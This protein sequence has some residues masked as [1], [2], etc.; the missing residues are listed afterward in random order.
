MGSEM[1]IRDRCIAHVVTIRL[2]RRFRH[3]FSS[4]RTWIDTTQHVVSN[5]PWHMHTSYNR[6][7][8]KR[9]KPSREQSA[10]DLENTSFI[11]TAQQ[12]HEDTLSQHPDI[13]TSRDSRK[14]RRCNPL[15]APGNQ[16][17]AS[18][19]SI[20]IEVNKR[21]FA[22]P[23]L[24]QL[25]CAALARPGAPPPRARAPPSPAGCR[26]CLLYTSPSPRDLSTS[27]M[28]SSA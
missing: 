12:H 20:R 25:R 14:T 13:S 7:G 6:K 2:L 19:S 22:P 1:C 28:P 9:G 3:S 10:K 27:R 26:T 23:Q 18:W 11:R 15:M 4:A 21:K 16:T 17:P 8:R 24:C 5:A